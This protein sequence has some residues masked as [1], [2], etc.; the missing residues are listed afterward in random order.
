M[1]ISFT[2]NIFK[3]P[4]SVHVVDI[5]RMAPS[6]AENIDPQVLFGGI[7]PLQGA[8]NISST[9]AMIKQ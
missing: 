3:S 6:K 4:T 2:W 7:K 5:S 1:M 9:D 8:A